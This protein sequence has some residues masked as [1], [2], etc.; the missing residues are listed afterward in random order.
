[1]NAATCCPPTIALWTPPHRR[2]A[3]AFADS[4]WS[5]AALVQRVVGGRRRAVAEALALA[6][7]DDRTRRDLG[8]AEGGWPEVPRDDPLHGWHGLRG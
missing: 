1:M 8:L 6:S 5:A 4:F 2:V 7:L 3:D